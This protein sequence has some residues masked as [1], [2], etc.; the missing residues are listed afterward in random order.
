MQFR[1]PSLKGRKALWWDEWTWPPCPHVLWDAIWWESWSAPS[2]AHLC[3]ESKSINAWH[4]LVIC[5]R[6]YYFHIAMPSRFPRHQYQ[7]NLSYNPLDLRGYMNTPH[8]F[9]SSNDG[10]CFMQS[11]FE[12][13]CEWRIPV[14]D[15]FFCI[16]PQKLASVESVKREVNKHSFRD[17]VRTYDTIL[18]CHPVKT[19]CLPLCHMWGCCHQCWNSRRCH[20]ITVCAKPTSR[21]MIA[22]AR[23]KAGKKGSSISSMP[24]DWS[25]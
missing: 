19:L 23:I 6:P 9:G 8:C 7:I 21:Q 22:F 16:I 25:K 5:L 17:L 18:I 1:G 10:H 2:F 11:N 15:I 4:S 3:G 14:Y 13:K 20:D 12:E 24:T